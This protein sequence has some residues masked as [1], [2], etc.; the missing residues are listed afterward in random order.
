MADLAEACRQAL[1]IGAGLWIQSAFLLSIGLAAGWLLR[2]KGPLFEAAAYRAALCAVL[3]SAFLAIALF[4][5]I[6]P[7]WHIALPV[8]TATARVPSIPVREALS[9][10]ARSRKIVHA[11]QRVRS[12]AQPEIESGHSRPLPWAQIYIG[13]AALWFVLSLAQILWLLLGAVTLLRIGRCPEAFRGSREQKLLE[14]LAGRA[15]VAVP[16]LIVHPRIRSPFVAG[17]FCPMIVVPI[18]LLDLD[19]PVARAVLSHEL[20]H[21]SQRDSAWVPVF[22]IVMALGWPQPLLRVLYRRWLSASEYACDRWALSNGCPPRDYAE[23]LMRLAEEKSTFRAAQALSLGV[24]PFRSLLGKRIQQILSWSGE[25]LHRLSRR[26]RYA[27]GGFAV[28]IGCAAVLLVSANTGARAT[29]RRFAQRVAHSITSLPGQSS[30]LSA[31]LNHNI[32]APQ[33]THMKKIGSRVLSTVAAVAGGLV[34]VNL[35]AVGAPAPAKSATAHTVSTTSAKPASKSA[36]KVQVTKSA[37]TTLPLTITEPVAK[38]TTMTVP[39]NSMMAQPLPPVTAD[40]LAHARQYKM[41]V[42]YIS[43][44]AMAERLNG[45]EIRQTGQFSSQARIVVSK[46]DNMLV[47]YASPEDFQRLRDIIKIIDVPVRQAQI[48]VTLVDVSE[49]NLKAWGLSSHS[50]GGD[51]NSKEIDMLTKAMKEGKLPDE[52]SIMLTANNTEEVTS[53]TDDP[54]AA[55]LVVAA[56]ATITSSNAVSTHLVGYL[57]VHGEQ[58]EAFSYNTLLLSGETSLVAVQPKGASKCRLIFVGATILADAQQRREDAARA[59]GDAPS[60]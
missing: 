38:I 54:E 21:L 46:A 34:Q 40:Y 6:R 56:T 51:P 59:A 11:E 13:L 2:R 33:G 8:H 28:L 45:D 55:G 25:R 22:R 10:S 49:A 17:V 14:E 19:E 29:T 48:R 35:P 30:R 26:A 44:A 4:G 20:G 24:A 9:T 37:P 5:R 12:S 41:P 53:N 18:G 31:S 15:G 3:L 42:D 16:R 57:P 27:M 23:C 52:R 43:A 50:L 39:A 36:A 47:V 60:P 7:I 1:Q 58:T 32:I